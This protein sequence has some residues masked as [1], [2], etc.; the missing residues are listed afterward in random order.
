MPKVIDRKVIGIKVGKG[1][2]GHYAHVVYQVTQI[3]KTGPK[4]SITET[5]VE[6]GPTIYEKDLHCPD[7]QHLVL[8]L[9][10]ML[11]PYMTLLQHT[12]WLYDTN[13]K[14]H[15]KRNQGKR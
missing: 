15:G 1:P 9:R 8:A 3:R 6:Q 5:V 7:E 4:R 12:E 13:R 11:E 14:K 10:V 2:I